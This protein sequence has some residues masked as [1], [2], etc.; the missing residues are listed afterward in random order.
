MSQLPTL[1][2]EGSSS[3]TGCGS[4]ASVEGRGIAGRFDPCERRRPK[5][6]SLISRAIPPGRARPGSR[7][8][9]IEE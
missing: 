9:T 1:R 7:C 4:A 5:D 8:G 6:L 2:F 3:T